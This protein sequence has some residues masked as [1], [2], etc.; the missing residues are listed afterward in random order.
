MSEEHSEVSEDRTTKNITAFFVL[1][2]VLSVPPYILAALVP[3]DMVMLTGLIIALAPI[4]AALILAY[5]ENG[6][7]AAKRLL[8]RSF[9]YKRITNKSWYLPILFF[10]PVLFFLAFGVTISMGET[11][12]DPLFPVVVAPVLF[13]LFFIFALFEEVGW[14]GYAFEPM[15][16][17]WNA[18]A[19]SLLLGLIWAIWHIPLYILAGLDPLWI[20][21]Q[22]ISL[23]GFR[24][25]IVFVFNNTGKSVFA[26]ILFHAMYNLCTILVT[27][28]YISTGHRLTSILIILTTLAVIILWD[29]DTLTQFRFRKVE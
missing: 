2:F 13:V 27:S 10:W 1:T 16:N 18:L 5:R 8:G 25:L 23:I 20:V 12:P 6:A 22:L 3:Q 24:T 7:D 11:P 21:E 15:E 17:R 29:P 28:F 9:D 4:T 14:M 26:A 19:A